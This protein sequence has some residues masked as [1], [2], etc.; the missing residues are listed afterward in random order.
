MEKKKRATVIITSVCAKV[1]PEKYFISTENGKFPSRIASVRVFGIT[2]TKAISRNYFCAHALRV[3]LVV[4]Q[5]IA[6]KSESTV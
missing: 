3:Y 6:S 1:A 2:S 5:V 4:L